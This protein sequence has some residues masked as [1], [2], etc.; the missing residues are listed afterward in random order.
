[1]RCVFV[2]L[3]GV[4]DRACKEL[5]GKTPLEAA[6]TPNLDW[7]ASN[8]RM[9]YMYAI[10]EG[11]VP[12]SDRALASIFGC[13]FSISRGQIEAMGSNIN[14][15]QG[16]LALRTNFA[17][18]DNINNGRII[19]RRAGRALTTKEA[20]TLSRDINRRLKLPYKFIFKPTVQHRGVLV[21][22]GG[23]SGNITDVDPAYKK[24]GVIRSMDKLRYSEPLDDEDV[25]RVSS[26]IVNEF[27]E[28]SY[29]ILKNHP[30]NKEREKKGLP[31]ANVIIAR[32]AGSEAVQTRKLE[33]RWMSIASM[34]LE[35]GISEI[36]GMEVFKFQYPVLKDYD[37]YQNLYEG[38]DIMINF[39]KRIIEKK[40][41]RF[42]YCYLHF[43]EADVPGHD[44]KPEEKKRMIEILDREFFSFLRQLAERGGIRVVVTAD[45]A[46]PCEVK[47]HSSDAVPLLVYGEGRD[48]AK[49][50]NET[51]CKMGS[52][53]KTY[54]RDILKLVIK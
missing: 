48:S 47:S 14:I 30:I 44:G 12:E 20:V 7:F 53:G 17:T 45:H 37:V 52:I 15:Q 6:S 28:Q 21:I 27:T 23:F 42:D 16:D 40:A 25:T 38:L 11:M 5:G 36:L 54:G 33:G 39:S 50:F 43:K 24:G 3:D 13:G 2:V 29:Y 19:D 22:R 41:G 35:I 26:N 10:K 1:M 34:P 51:E 31:P 32:G 9:G 49:R 4:G 46:T 8:G 18:I